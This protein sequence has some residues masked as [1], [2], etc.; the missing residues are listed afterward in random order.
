M[1]E[2]A[3]IKDSLGIPCA[4]YV[5]A[6]VRS[7]RVKAVRYERTTEAARSSPGA[8]AADECGPD[9][10]AT[11]LG[12]RVAATCAGDAVAMTG[13]ATARTGVAVARTGVGIE[14]A[15]A[16]ACAV[17]PT[18]RFGVAPLF[19]VAASVGV[20]DGSG[21]G[22]CSCVGAKVGDGVTSLE[23]GVD[24]GDG[25]AATVV[26]G[27]LGAPLDPPKKCA[28]TPPS[29]SPAKTTTKTS[30][31]SGNPPPRGSSSDLRRRG[32]SFM[33]SRRHAR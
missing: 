23:N 1:R 3:P 18:T 31:K 16:V 30:G 2:L 19:G 6:L 21:V 32:G 10:P 9:A 29:S 27:A 24:N 11:T 25:A 22:L 28:S 5:A 12:S 33:R 26:G 7:P 15:V 14:L 8:L 4:R 17:N 20:I 13:V